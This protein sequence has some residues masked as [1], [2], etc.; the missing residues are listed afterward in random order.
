MAV[1]T[2]RYTKVILTIIAVLLLALLFKPDVQKAFTP[3]SANAVSKLEGVQDPDGTP[4][5]LMDVYVRNTDGVPVPMKAI[6]KVEVSWDKPMPVYI[7]E[8]KDAVK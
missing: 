7:V 2:D 5:M 6:G 1:K 4:I 8:K 3:T